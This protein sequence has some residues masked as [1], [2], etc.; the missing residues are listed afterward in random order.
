[1]NPVAL[2]PPLRRIVAGLETTIYDPVTTGADYR[3]RTMSQERLFT[4]LL[5]VFGALALFI[6]CIGIYGTAIYLVRRRTPE[7]GI[8][9]SLGARQLDVVRLVIRETLAP[10]AI[11]IAAGIAAAVELAKL[12]VSI[13]FGVSQTDPWSIALAA[14]LLLLT[15]AC[16]A[17]IPATHCIA[18]RAVE[19]IEI[20]MRGIAPVRPTTV[21]GP[22]AP[23]TTV[24]IARRR[25]K[26]C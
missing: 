23:R 4:V 10:V 3:A 8:R 17:A 11:G 16:A 2:I 12:A 1:V 9:M 7:I 21:S 14:S 20:R 19:G 15:A 13:L 5:S 26:R 18:D 24:L 25:V 6:A 22:V